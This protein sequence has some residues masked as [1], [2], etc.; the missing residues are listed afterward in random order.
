MTEEQLFN[1][2]YKLYYRKCLLFA[3]SYTHDL[4]KA[5]DIVSEAMVVLWE[6]MS[7]SEKIN[8]ILPFLMGTIRNKVLLYFRSQRMTLK[9]RSTLEEDNIRELQIR[10]STLEECDPHNL[11]NKDVSQIVKNSLNS[12][13]ERSK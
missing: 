13:G 10:M 11:Y 3:R 5:E 7:G 9:F 6:K 2:A 4:A 1:E 12:M 8:A